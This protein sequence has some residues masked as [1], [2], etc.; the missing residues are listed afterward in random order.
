MPNSRKVGG[1]GR[2]TFRV[3]K[4]IRH[5]PAVGGGPTWDQQKWHQ[6]RDDPLMGAAGLGFPVGKRLEHRDSEKFPTSPQELKHDIESSSSGDVIFILGHLRLDLTSVEHPIAVP[7]GVTVASNRNLSRGWRGAKLRVTKHPQPDSHAE[8]LFECKKNSRITGLSID[9]TVTEYQQWEGYGSSPIQ[10][11]ISIEGDHVEV[12]NCSIRGWPHAAVEVGWTGTWF[13]WHVH[14]CDLVDNIQ[15]GF[16]YGVA[17][18]HGNGLIQRNYFDNNRHSISADGY[19]DCSYVSRFNLVG[20][21]T[22]SHAFDM[23]A[24]NENVSGAGA[25]GGKRV[26]IWANEFLC[27]RSILNSIGAQEAIRLRGN[28][29]DGAQILMNKFAHSSDR[30]DSEGPGDSGQAVWLSSGAES[31][32]AANVNVDQNIATP[33]ASVEEIVGLRPS[34]LG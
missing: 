1:R 14:D 25:Q 20:P 34:I 15:D 12:D 24:G 6:Q 26:S 16:G 29:T 19:K 22:K 31:F 9:G 28:P 17:V 18:H 3:P 2:Y 8:P 30:Y 7:E 33:A 27:T 13:D 32:A 4:R 23:H 11:A 5:A 10:A 21:R